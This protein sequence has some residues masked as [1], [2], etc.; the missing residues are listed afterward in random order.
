MKLKQLLEQL[1][2]L[3]KERPEALEMELGSR[4]KI[5]F[6]ALVGWI[7]KLPA[8][9]MTKQEFD[10]YIKSIPTIDKDY[11]IIGKQ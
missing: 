7:L 11:L 1:N 4:D 3:A 8:P 9:S 5:V 10:N 6:E 2:Q